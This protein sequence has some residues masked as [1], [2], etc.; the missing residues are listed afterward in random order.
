MS[1]QTT[2]KRRF[3]DGL[4]V[5][6]ALELSRGTESPLLPAATPRCPR[7]TISAASEPLYS[8]L[9]VVLIACERHPQVDR[10]QPHDVSQSTYG[11][12]PVGAVVPK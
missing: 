10:T 1:P 12:F 7:S 3:A 11:S 6:A 9:R 5:G 2:W 8:L 4:A